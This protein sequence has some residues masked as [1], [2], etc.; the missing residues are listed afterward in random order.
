MRDVPPALWFS[1]GMSITAEPVIQYL[2]QL[3]EQG[4][5]HISLDDEARLILRQFYMRAQGKL[6]KKNA[7][8][9]S[10]QQATA[11]P[12]HLL[13][14][15]PA[16]EKTPQTTPEAAPQTDKISLSGNTPAEKLVQLKAHTANYPTAKALGT[17]RQTMIFSAGTPNA[18]IMLIGDSPGFDDERIGEPFIGKAGQKLTGILQ[19]MNIKREDAYLTHIVKYR[20]SS[21]NQTT[22]TRKPSTE[23]FDAFLPILQEEIKIIAPKVIIAL[24]AKTAQALLT[25]EISV[26]QVRGKFHS[27]LGV[28]LRATYHP[29]Y[30][31]QD[32]NTPQKRELWED[33]LSVMELLNMP[34]SEKQQGYFKQK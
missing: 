2:R 10:P 18:D 4:Q 25:S 17:L 22:M 9:P 30:I 3:Q 11:A 12:A 20:P 23:E 15:T 8:S 14:E 28:P 1:L 13:R 6:P 33:M 34:I 19:A 31:L 16:A 21:A 27:Y 26:D 7:S 29:S 5:T 32:G 24:G